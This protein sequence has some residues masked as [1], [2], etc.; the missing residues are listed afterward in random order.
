MNVGR[1]TDYNPE[2]ITKSRTYIESCVDEVEEYHRG[3][4]D[5]SNTYERLVRVRLPTVEGLAGY[6]SVARSTVYEWKDHHG[7]FSDIVEEL[8]ANQAEKL[9]NN[10]LSGNYNP[11]ITKLLL[12]KHGYKE[13]REDDKPRIVGNE[14]IFRDFSDGD[15][16]DEVATH[17]PKTT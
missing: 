1:P 4:G 11:T 12:T 17:R 2:I 9:I 7:E 3:R 16:N 14:I 5:K 13:S 10:G 6:L 15:L 8:L